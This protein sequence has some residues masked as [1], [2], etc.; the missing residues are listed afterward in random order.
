MGGRLPSAVFIVIV[1][2]LCI[3][4]HLTFIEPRH[5]CLLVNICDLSLD[6]LSMVLNTF[7][8]LNGGVS[9]SVDGGLC[10]SDQ[11]HSG[12]TALL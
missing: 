4:L 12:G 1:Q 7:V 8:S 2:G 3:P 9:F 5:I 10:S 6:L 11:D